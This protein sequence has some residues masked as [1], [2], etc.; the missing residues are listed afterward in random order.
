MTF[1]RIFLAIVFSLALQGCMHWDY[2]D[3]EVFDVKAPG[4]FIINEGNFQYG[5]ATLSFYNPQTNQVS[6]EIFLR[7][8][9]MKLGDVAQSMTVFGDKGWVVVNN[10]HVVFAIGLD[11]F[12]ECGRIEGLTSPR[13]IHFIDENKAYVSQLWDNRIFVVDPSRYS[14]TGYIAVP[15]TEASTGST[16]QM[17]GL[18]DYVYCNCWSYQ[19]SIIKIDPAT[20][21]V[22]GKLE[23]GIQPSSLV[24]DSKGRLWVLTDGGY[25]GSE[26]GYEA[27]ALYCV[28]TDDF[29]VERVLRFSDGDMV[30]GLTINSHGDKLYWINGGVWAMDVDSERLPGRP[31]IDSRNTRYYCL[32]VDSES[33]DIYVADAIDYQQ[34]GVVY[35]YGAE[36]ELK[37]EFYTGVTPGGFCWKR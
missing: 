14:V 6:N 32:T 13:Y 27:P 3:E 8:N 29:V 22:V 36:G 2:G 33:G 23:V 15:D 10:S 34:Q 20:D 7:A 9:G 1:R 31:I 4:L 30:R 35:R 12:K 28:N 17:I 18:G 11:T 5:N 25:Q 16:E 19:S 24:A 21:R 37:D 26:Y